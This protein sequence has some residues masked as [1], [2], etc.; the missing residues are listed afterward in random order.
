MPSGAGFAV[1]ADELSDAA[2][3]ALDD[4]ATDVPL[5]LEVVAGVADA[6]ADWVGVA[7]VDFVDDV[8]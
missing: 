8:V 5:E 4:G 6:D 2:G 3:V 1:V 7:E